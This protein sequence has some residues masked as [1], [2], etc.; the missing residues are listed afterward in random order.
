MQYTNLELENLT[1]QWGIDRKITI[2]GK[3]ETQFLKLIEESGE[4]FSSG[5]DIEKIKDA[6]GDQL[7][8]LTMINGLTND[9]F[10]LDI[11][12]DQPSSFSEAVRILCRIQ[13]ELASNIVRSK[14]SEISISTNEYL[15][16]LDYFATFFKTNINECWNYAYNEIKDRKGYLAENGCFI[17]EEDYLK[18]D[19]IL[20]KIDFFNTQTVN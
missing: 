14:I 7:V 18:K 16:I 2:N 19:S 6:I 9:R 4:I 10:I 13:G 15:I 17:K 1:L 5:G 20:D 8:V 11:S 3:L 12:I